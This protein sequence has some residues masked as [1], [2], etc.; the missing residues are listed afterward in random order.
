MNR[1]L[2]MTVGKTHS[3]RSTFG[4]DLAGRLGNACVIDQDNHAAFVNTYYQ[5][6]LPKHGLN[7]LKYSLSETVID[8]ALIRTDVHVILCNAYRSRAGRS[9]LLNKFRAH[10]FTTV[11]VN[12]DLPDEV[13]TARVAN[14]TRSTAVLRSASS[15]AEVLTRQRAESGKGGVTPPEVGEAD[16]M[17][18]LEHSQEVPSVIDQI[19]ELTS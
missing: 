8:Y 9:K 12:F 3:G 1:L 18:R 7:L 10:G 6:L 17:F 5:A 19:L 2:V 15:F 16:F 13:L 11:L 14:T 4:Q